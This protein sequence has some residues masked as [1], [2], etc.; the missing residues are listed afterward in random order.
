M[1]QSTIIDFLEV[2]V[3]QQDYKVLEQVEFSIQAGEFYYIIGKVGSGKTTLI[4]TINAEI[5]LSGGRASV[6]GYKLDDLQERDVP[7]LR[8]KLGVVFQDFKLLTDRSIYD[9]LEF[10]LQATGWRSKKDIKNRIN[11]VLALVDLKSHV[12]KFPHELSGGEQQKSVI[13]RA[14][15]NEP[16]IIL[17]DEPT[18]NLDPDTSEEIMNLLFGLNKN[19]KTILM[20]TH[21]YSLMKKYPHKALRIKDKHITEENMLEEIID[22]TDLQF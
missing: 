19:G 21:N 17:A 3:Y 14:I 6:A 20:V 4:K 13:A 9:N 15:L 16:E 8:R 2:D 22:F 5:S 7:Y 11:E 10:V 18:G 12:N 1:A